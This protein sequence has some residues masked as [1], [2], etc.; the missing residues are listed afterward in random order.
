MVVRGVNFG[1]VRCAPVDCDR[2]VV[3]AGESFPKG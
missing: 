2:E 1:T 3:D